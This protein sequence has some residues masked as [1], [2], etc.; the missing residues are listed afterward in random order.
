[1]ISEHTLNQIRDRLNLVDI[2]G[3]YVELKKSGQGF[4]GLCPFHNEKTPSFHVHPLKQVFKC[5]GCQKGGNL[6]TFYSAVNAL[7]FPEAVTELAKRAGVELEKEEVH[8][9]DKAPVNVAN[10]RLTEV[11]EW[12]A[13][14]FHFLLTEHKD[15][16][17]AREYLKGRGITEKTTAAFQIGVAPKG[18]STL[19]D[20]MIK[21]NFTFAELVSS[22][23]IIPR[24]KQPNDG[25]D[26]FRER[27]MFPIRD[28]EGD[29]VGFG[30]RLLTEEENQPKYLNTSESPLFSK[31]RILYGLHQNARSIRMREEALIVEGYMDVVGLHQAGVNN[32]VATMGTAL[33]EE[34]CQQ[35]KSLTRHVVT[36][37]DPDKAGVDA[38]HRSVHTL[39]GAGMFAKDL[40]LPDGQDPDEYVLKHGADS[41]HELCAKAPR[42]VNKLLMEIAQ[43]GSLT[44]E[45]SAKAL[46][47]L[48][49]L[50]VASRRLPDRAQ[51]WDDIS[52]VLKVSMEA[53]KEMAE[54]AYRSSRPREAAP[55]KSAAPVSR[56][57]ITIPVRAPKPHPLDLELYQAAIHWPDLF[58][59]IPP[60]EWNDV[61]K[62]GRLKQ[63]LERLQ[64]TDNFDQE[65]ELLVQ[66]EASPYLLE[67]A[68]AKL[69]GQSA[70]D[71]GEAMIAALR[72]RLTVVRKKR[73]ITALTTQV[74][75]GQRLGNEEEQL[76]LLERLRELRSQ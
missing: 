5:F 3:E 64:A 20:L 22:G 17:F 40:S 57:K 42:Q 71:K 47:E 62:D 31:R 16:E 30:G 27:L 33:T 51:L 65:L 21:R 7:P 28:I 34:H 29:V 68:S 59:E 50:L 38:W 48:T 10:K 2:V 75:L 76:K 26:R 53:L 60:T 41:F 39:M 36:I 49:P 69:M 32:A 70:P 46:E 25:Y 58:R 52:L 1:M 15:Y 12:A 66:T 9:K 61:V 24:E 18:W 63:W 67:P 37:F 11:N 45:A 54:S 55:V 56:G 13:K 14:Y 72:A 73:E 6:F 4:T 44:A 74:K 43:R 35:L 8:R 19:R 23:L